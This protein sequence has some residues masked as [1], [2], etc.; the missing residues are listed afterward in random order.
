MSALRPH[1]LGL[2]RACHQFIKPL[3]RECPHCGANV[4]RAALDYQERHDMATRAAQ[5]LNAL[6]AELGLVSPHS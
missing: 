3:E 5:D 4:L 1:Q 2:C 6:L